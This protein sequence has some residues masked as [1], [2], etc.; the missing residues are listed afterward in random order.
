MLEE[1]NGVWGAMPRR[2]QDR[3][4]A[5]VKE[6]QD[7]GYEVKLKKRPVIDWSAQPEWIVGYCIDGGRNV[8]TRNTHYAIMDLSSVMW[9][10]E[11]GW[12]CNEVFSDVFI[13]IPAEHSPL[14]TFDGHPKDS[15]V[16]RPGVARLEQI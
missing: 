15:L 11:D 10:D 6:L 1:M 3:V 8:L 9:S 16:V 14:S 12:I 4:E 2:L 5:L 13:Q 7:L